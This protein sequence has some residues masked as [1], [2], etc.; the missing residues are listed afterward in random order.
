[1]T[2]AQL[3]AQLGGALRS[4]GIAATPGQCER[5]ARALGF[6]GRAGRR[7]VYWL[8]RICFLTAPEQLRAFERAL[9]RVIVR[10]CADAAETEYDVPATEA[11]LERR[12]QARW[13]V[14]V[15]LRPGKSQAAL[16]KRLDG[17]R[18]VLVLPLADEYLVA[19]D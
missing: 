17:E 19:D 5:F 4:E 13:I 18:Q 7:R 8:A 2:A 9:A 12:A 11:A 10:C 15:V 3:A 6:A 16:G 14:A 1:M